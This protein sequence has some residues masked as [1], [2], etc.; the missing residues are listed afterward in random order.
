MSQQQDLLLSKIKLILGEEIEYKSD[1][2]P[3]W[4][5]NPNTGKNLEIDIYIPYLS[6]GFEYQGYHHFLNAGD[7]MRNND[8][9]KMK[10]SKRYGHP[11]IEIFEN[12][13][14]SKN[15]K[16]IFLSR[17]EVQCNLQTYNKVTCL[18]QQ[19]EFQDIADNQL[20]SERIKAE[21]DSIDCLMN[22][23]FSNYIY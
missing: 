16:S 20:E 7:K 22:I 3:D 9:I 18:M 14:F 1:Y 5:K 2:R 11:I 19:K 23:D 10:L 6:L 21:E 8:Y 4:L 15:F 12:D 13:L 17:I